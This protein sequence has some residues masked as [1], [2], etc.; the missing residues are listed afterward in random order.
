[1]P[2]MSE[3][4]LP[5][6]PLP[7]YLDRFLLTS[8]ALN[9]SAETIRTR[10]VC[11]KR[12]IAWC[13]QR[14]LTQPQDVTASVLT[15]YRLHL[16]HY[17]KSNGDPLSASTQHSQLAPIK[18]F[19][20]WLNA[21]NHILCD[22]AANFAL[23]R[24][25]KHL[26]KDI[27]SID[28][29]EAMLQHTQ[30]YGDKGIRDRAIIETFYSSGIRRIELIGLKLRDID[31]TR[32]TLTVLGK[33]KRDRVVP[34]GARACAWVKKYQDDVRP[35][36]IRGE[37]TSVLFLTNH[38]KPY[39]KNRLT[40]LIKKYKDAVGITKP[41]ACHLFRHTMAT[42]MLENGADV[43]YIQEIL[44]HVNLSSTEIYTQVSIK[45]LKEVHTATHPAR[46]KTPD[47]PAD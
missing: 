11:L 28:E 26:P 37:D 4:T 17:R 30:V 43:R 39:L 19:F 8:R 29:I 7:L 36:L 38:G 9:Y 18:A 16:F 44:G 12:F 10:D 46:I 1:M 23:P 32:G 21:E 13:E 42:H 27:L 33:G 6:Q 35:D 25:P 14:G 15:R 34:I 5:R 47:D 45:K 31:Y 24:T 22:P 20:K 3:T 40:D 41:G 2:P